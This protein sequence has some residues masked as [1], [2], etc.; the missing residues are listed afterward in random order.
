MKKTFGLVAVAAALTLTACSGGGEANTANVANE[1]IL[2]ENVA[3][4]NVTDLTNETA[5][6]VDAGNAVNATD[7]AAN[8]TAANASNAAQ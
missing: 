4:E 2:E 5:N 7:A 8:A 6:A 1:L 3:T